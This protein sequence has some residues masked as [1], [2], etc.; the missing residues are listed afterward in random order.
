M[1]QFV[2]L[3]QGLEYN[4]WRVGIFSWWW[5][6]RKISYNTHVK[7]I[8]LL[9]QIGFLIAK[10]RKKQRLHLNLAHNTTE[11]SHRS[12]ARSCFRYNYWEHQNVDSGPCT[13]N[14]N[15]SCEDQKPETLSRRHVSSCFWLF[16]GDGDVHGTQKCWFHRIKTGEE[17]LCA[18]EEVLTI[19]RNTA[20]V[21]LKLLHC[22]H[23]SSCQ[24]DN[25]RLSL[26]QEQIPQNHVIRI[27]VGHI[28]SNPK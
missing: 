5:C 3:S 28:I 19:R 23:C 27:L 14:K 20:Y 9:L 10:K 13:T 6:N 22:F 26:T 25:Q 21:E 2:I 24:T 7:D 18:Q 8:E 16:Q 1:I 4:S 15:Y 11:Y 17:V 12:L